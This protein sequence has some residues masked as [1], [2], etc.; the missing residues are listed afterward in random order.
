VTAAKLDVYNHPRLGYEATWKLRI[1]PRY[2]LPENQNQRRSLTQVKPLGAQDKP[3]GC[4][5]AF[6]LR[7]LIPAPRSRRSESEQFRSQ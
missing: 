4:L 3:E 2:T 5:G 6:I 1:A 7:S